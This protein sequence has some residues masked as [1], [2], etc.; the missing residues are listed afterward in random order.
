MVPIGTGGE[1]P[2]G[3]V[4]L[5]YSLRSAETAPRYNRTQ[6]CAYDTA[7]RLA[8]QIG[9]VP[10][11][12]GEEA[13][14][15]MIVYREAST[16]AR[17]LKID[18]RTLYAV[19]NSLPAHYHLVKIPKRDGGERQLAVPDEVLKRVQRGI[20]R[21]LLA[22]LPV[23]PYATAYRCG[24]GAVRNAARHM[25]RPE[26]L[27]LDIRRCFDSVRYTAVK[28][29]VFPPER[30]SEPLRVL[31]TMLCYYRDGLPQGAPTSPA[32]INILLREFDE[33]MG[34]WCRERGITYSR[35]CDDL[36][37][38]GQALDGVRE[39]AEEGLHALGFC[40]HENK[41]RL[42]RDGQRQ[43]VT[44]LVVNHGLHVPSED[45]RAVRQA[46]YYCRKFGVEDHLRRTGRQETPQAYL[47]RLLGW[48]G[49][50]LSVDPADRTAAQNR[51]WLLA[52]RRRLQN[53]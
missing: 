34:G 30:F 6:G 7:A 18:V 20:Y 15:H 13:S 9:F 37:F 21:N 41:A 36:T 26:V 8:M 33:A 46:V 25:G 39:K 14:A 24:S 16:L 4:I 31:L 40:L 1:S 43:E 38:S 50:I 35:Y 3:F 51:Q 17:D 42:R 22:Y 48:T 27:C 44:G 10:E 47:D 2:P 11:S 53:R 32:I 12:W 45:R 28:E 29:A 5:A 23:S 49:Y 52:E 19:S